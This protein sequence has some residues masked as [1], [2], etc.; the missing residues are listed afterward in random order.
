MSLELCL[1]AI[2]PTKL[3]KAKQGKE[4]PASTCPGFS[5]LY[6]HFVLMGGLVD[7]SPIH[8]RLRKL[9]LTPRGLVSLAERGHLIHGPDER[10]H[11]LDHYNY[12]GKGIAI[13]Y[14]FWVAIQ[15]IGRRA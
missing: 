3:S 13:M 11:E 7:V 6:W 1:K 9:I 15:C 12:L 5:L 2:R 4:G 8:D 10:I 14:A